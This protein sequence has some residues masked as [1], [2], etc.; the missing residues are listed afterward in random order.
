MSI[1]LHV[2]LR[3]RIAFAC[4][5][6]YSAALAG[7][8]AAQ[9]LRLNESLGPGSPEAEALAVFKKHVEDGS[10]GSLKVA[11][12]FQDQLGN[13]QTSTEN[14]MTGSLDLYSGALEYYEP[15]AHDEFGVMSLAYFIPDPMHLLQYIASPTFQAA[16]QKILDRGI[17]F[18][19]I[20]AQ[21]G[22]Y[23]VIVTT[24]PVLRVEDLQGL[25][26][27]MFPN[28]IAIRSWQNLGTVTLQVPFDQVY[29]GLRQG[30]IQGVTAPLSAIRSMKFT[31]VAPYVTAIRE[32]PQV[33]PITVSERVY[34]KLSP[35]YQKLLV[36]AAAEAADTYTAATIQHGNEDIAAMIHDNN[37]V[38][39][40]VNTAPFRKK[41]EPFYQQLLK[42]GAL[43]QQVYDTV[44]AILAH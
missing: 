19:E 6:F 22:P 34:Q 42:E 24:K 21:R 13:P 25:K 26:L 38:F 4:A 1:A 18:L 32:F 8:H 17:R 41:M 39:I 44:N 11:L 29:L 20:S 15:L 2:A 3:L 33:W 27:R 35:E 7:A 31:E 43:N 36:D 5:I 10:G 37:A 28:Q 12:F 40:D 23:R 14:L 30:V 9:T 16:R